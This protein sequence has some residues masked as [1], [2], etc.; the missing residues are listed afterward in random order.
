MNGEATSVARVRR[1]AVPL[2]I[3]AV[4]VSVLA[5]CL[6]ACGA[7]VGNAQADELTSGTQLKTQATKYN[8]WVGG[9]Q[10]T[11]ANKDNVLGD[12]KKSVSYNPATK[13]LTLKNAK[14]KSSR[15]WTA[16]PGFSRNDGILAIVSGTFTVKLVGTNTITV[17]SKGAKLCAAISCYKGFYAYERGSLVITG[18]GTLT[19]TAAKAK[20][21]SWG[22]DTESLT[23]KGKAN[24]TVKG[25]TAKGATSYGAGVFGRI[26]ITDNAQVTAIGNTGAFYDASPLYKNYAPLVKAGDSAKKSKVYKKNPARTVYKQS[27]YV[28]I[29]KATK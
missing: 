1:N 13:T 24:V 28:N 19:A 8:V 22:I 12:K 18:D 5:A 9:K 7:F 20:S 26:I 15:Q 11:S 2:K 23:V 25:S 4:A 29:T 21:Y 27:K 10:V 6:L 3:L 16:K 14:I 17:P